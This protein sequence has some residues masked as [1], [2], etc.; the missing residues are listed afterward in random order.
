MQVCWL[1]VVKGRY[2]ERSGKLNTTGEPPAVANCVMTTRD[3]FRPLA[4]LTVPVA[5]SHVSDMLVHTADVLMVGQLGAVPLAGVQ[6]ASSASLI[7]ALFSIGYAAAITPLA[8]EAYGR[9][10]M[11]GVAQY[12]RSGFVVSTGITAVMCVLLLLASSR[13]DLLGSPPEVTAQATPYFRWIVLSFL[14]RIMFGAFKQTAEAMANTRVAM[15]LNLATNIANVLLNW[16][17]I[18]GELG[19]PAMGAEGAGFA[20]FLA[21][22]G[23]VVAAWIV[24]R[25]ARFFAPLRTAVHRLHGTP[26]LGAAARRILHDGT[27]IALQILMEVAGFACGAIMLGWISA[28]AVAAH[29]IA[30]N[31][32]SITFMVALGLGS[33]A[34]IRI[35][36]LRGEG[37]PAEARHA[38]M[39]SLVLVIGYM[40]FVGMGYLVLRFWLPTLYVKDEN[41]IALASHLLLYAAA[42]SLFD[43]L[44][45]VGLGIL[46]GYN[47]VQIPTVLASISYIAITIPAS[48]LFAF[49]FEFNAPGVWMGYLTGLLFA[50]A[51]YLWRFY[52]VVRPHTQTATEGS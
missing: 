8:G 19:M 7:A 12:A 44:Q 23:A 24:Y 50:S 46:R 36:N 16:I 40:L 34:T 49:T 1:S 3:Q 35:S 28:T 41:V 6:I 21:R 11:P 31:M 48:F 4:S 14:V 17:F 10:D 32:A 51:A 5:A 33:A 9:R 30:I 52:H 43:G 18:Y 45:V 39:A 20:T 42:F 29:S 15:I 38:A 27:G 37:K 22:V 25:R 13:L 2:S 26:V 47:D